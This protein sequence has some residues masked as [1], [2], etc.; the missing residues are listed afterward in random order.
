MS[1]S[2]RNSRSCGT[3]SSGSVFSTVAKACCCTCTTQPTPAG[4][5]P[6]RGRP[7]APRRPESGA[8]VYFHLMSTPPTLVLL[9]KPG[10]DGHDR[11]VNVIAR[12]LRDAG[13]EVI[14]SGLRLTREPIVPAGI[15]EGV[16]CIGLP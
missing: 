12:A 15:H 16:D 13:M 2:F 7:R 1:S 11:G 3:T 4:S 9:V 14:Y 6:R 10:L 5:M 8:A